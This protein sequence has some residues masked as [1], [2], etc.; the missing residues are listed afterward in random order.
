MNKKATDN[1][2]FIILGITFLLSCI[3][4]LLI[5]SVGYDDA[6]PKPLYSFSQE[7]TKQLIFM[8]IGTIIGVAALI[9]DSKF[10]S[11]FGHVVY[12][13]TM[14]LL[15]A[16]FLFGDEVNGARSWFRFGSISI[17]PSEFA[18]LGTV[19]SIACFLN[20][21]KINLRNKV[22]LFK[23][24]GIIILPVVLIILQKDAG[25]ALVFLGLFGVLY[26]MGMSQS[27]FIIALGLITIV[28]LAIIVPTYILTS[29]ILITCITILLFHLK[30]ANIVYCILLGVSLA[31]AISLH[32]FF[33][34]FEFILSIVLGIVLIVVASKDFRNSF[35]AKML[36]TFSIVSVIITQSI[37]HVFYNDSIVL[38]H[39]RDR[40]LVWLKPQ[41][42]FGSD[43][44]YNVDKSE[45]AIGSGGFTGSGYLEGNV[46]KLN[47]VPEQSTDFIFCSVGEQFGFLG[48]S[49][50]LICTL[51]C[52]YWYDNGYSSHYW[53][54]ATVCKCR[55]VVIDYLLP[56]DRYSLE[57]RR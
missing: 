50:Y 15:V 46:T 35:L 6:D 25:T 45:M 18:K 48:S 17:Q 56:D 11:A 1:L 9:T 42:Y 29:I 8:G 47:F 39:Q 55:W 24:M 51:R 43:E 21:N 36:L 10:Y 30:M 44:R 57:S 27:F 49:A 32:L 40:I 7:H 28:I 16:V 26:A 23:A 54:S 34:S 31:G 12:A 19:L 52:Q 5:Y 2:D 13:I 53:Y 41:N 33:P 20:T 38:P 3:G 37:T 4:V 14:L 22:F